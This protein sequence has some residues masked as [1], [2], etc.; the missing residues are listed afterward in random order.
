MVDYDVL[1]AVAMTREA[2]APG[3]QPVHEVAPD[4][5]VFEWHLGNKD[6]TE[7]A[8]ARPRTSPSS[9]SSTTA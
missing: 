3:A 9:T 4:N 2:R 8:F 6:E 1:P 5:T 7:A